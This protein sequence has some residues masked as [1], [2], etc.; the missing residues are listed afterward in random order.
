VKGNTIE[1]Q[2]DHREKIVER[3]RAA[4]HPAKPAGG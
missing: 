3:L 1:I 4:G 2:G